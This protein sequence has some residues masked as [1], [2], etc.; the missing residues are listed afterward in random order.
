MWKVCWALRYYEKPLPAGYEVEW[1][2]KPLFV[3]VYEAPEVMPPARE[4]SVRLAQG[5]SNCRHTLRLIPNHD[6]PLAIKAF[7]V[8]R[9]PLTATD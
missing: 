5:L 3:D 7:R 9:P 6:G 2:V 4:A 1:R 8:Y